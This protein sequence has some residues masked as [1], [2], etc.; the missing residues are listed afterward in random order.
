MPAPGSALHEPICGLTLCV[1]VV[2]AWWYLVEAIEWN[3]A[4]SVPFAVAAVVFGLRGNYSAAM[5]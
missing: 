2:F 5:R 3:H 4:V 1:F